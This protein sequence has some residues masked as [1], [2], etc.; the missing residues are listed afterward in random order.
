MHPPAPPTC[1]LVTYGSRRGGTAEIA[2]RIAETLREL[3]RSADCL[4]AAEVTD[5]ARYGAVIVGGSLYAS[6]WHRDARRF[7]KRHTAAL[8]QRPVWMFSSGPL[9][10]S[11]VERVIPP[12]RQ[13][14]S[15]IARVRARSHAT[16]GGRLVREPSGFIAA[17][18]A[19]KLAGDWRDWEQVR[20]WAREI[21]IALDTER[22]SPPISADT[23]PAASDG[24]MT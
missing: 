24:P 11:A 14:A 17:A 3:G 13:V 9:D 22:E 2:E 5:L 6:R 18:M 19:K 15:L 7:V 8:A 10:A 20:R 12:V 1:V 23:A 4:P 16:F 21:A